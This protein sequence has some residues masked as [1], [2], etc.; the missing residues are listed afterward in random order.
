MKVNMV[1]LMAYTLLQV[2]LNSWFRAIIPHRSNC[3][4]S[5]CIPPP[6]TS[7]H[8]LSHYPTVKLQYHQHQSR[9]SPR[10]GSL[11]EIL[12]L[13]GIKYRHIGKL[14]RNYNW[15]TPRGVL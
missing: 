15:A 6:S 1:L 5:A 2:A 3:C 12:P 9:S 14:Q 4:Y 7:L 11:G 13:S 8:C 10:R